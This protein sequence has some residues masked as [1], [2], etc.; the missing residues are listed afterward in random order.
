MGGLRM[1]K[2]ASNRRVTATAPME[3]RAA[4][5][6]IFGVSRMITPVFIEF[7]SFPACFCVFTRVNGLCEVYIGKRTKRIG[8]IP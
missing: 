5:T 8:R 3:R 6:P 1:C 7:F 4:M 2:L